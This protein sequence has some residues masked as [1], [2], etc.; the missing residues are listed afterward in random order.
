MVSFMPYSRKV[1]RF[2]TRNHFWFCIVF[3][4][5]I[6][7]L[8]STITA[9]EKGHITI[10]SF[11]IR[12]SGENFHIDV[13]TD[14][15]LSKTMKQAL[16]KGVSLYFVTRLL[17]VKPR[18]YWFDEEVSRS[19]TRVELS[20]QALTR[21]YRLVQGGQP[22]N[23]PTL[24]AALQALGH[25]PDLLIK[26]TGPLLSDITYTAILQM[27]LDISRLSKPFQLEWLDTEDWNLSSEKKIWQL[28][29][30]LTPGTNK[31]SDLN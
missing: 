18:W 16:E 15:T 7:L 28:K 11:Q 14:I 10:K 19:K 20:Y 6:V 30:P 22:Q 29:F 27:W 4:L 12:Q 24:K 21:Q 17:V 9:A 23:F 8:P 3:S 26:E 2:V 1:D 25:Q 5:L 13:E 31:A